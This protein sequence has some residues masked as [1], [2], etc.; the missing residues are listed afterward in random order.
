[1][2]SRTSEVESRKLLVWR[3]PE[4]RAHERICHICGCDEYHACRTIDDTC[5]WVAW[6]LCSAC[7]FDFAIANLAARQR[8]GDVLGTMPSHELARW[9]MREIG[10]IEQRA[11]ASNERRAA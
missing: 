3:P 9:L 1:M 4:E 10:E 2:E 5:H 6:D 11:V 8:I 7:L